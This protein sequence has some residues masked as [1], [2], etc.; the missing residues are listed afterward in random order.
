MG[1]VLIV[2]PSLFVAFL[3]GGSLIGTKGMIGKKLLFSLWIFFNVGVTIAYI[4]VISMVFK[5]W[6]N[7]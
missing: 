2:L 1:I 4:A 5:G 3:W 6:V 7:Y